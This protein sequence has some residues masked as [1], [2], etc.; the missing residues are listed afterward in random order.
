MKIY[1]I[2]ILPLSSLSAICQT[3]ESIDSFINQVCQTQFTDSVTMDFRSA[4]TTHPFQVTSYFKNDTLLMTVGRFKNSSR[5]RFTY[6][7]FVNEQYANVLCV[8]DI[9]SSKNKIIL[10]VYGREGI[11]IPSNILKITTA[12]PLEIN[13]AVLEYPSRLLD[14]SNYSIRAMF[15]LINRK[16][17]EYHFKGIL[18]EEVPFPPPCGRVAFAIAQKFEVIS[19][20]FPNYK[21][22]FV[23]IIKACPEGLKKFFVKGKTYDLDVLTNSGVTFSY[24]IDNKYQKDDLPIFWAKEIKIL[25]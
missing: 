22:K 13:S 8:R 23:I 3:V 24:S 20:N 17:T 9:D 15:A 12:E 4:D 14:Y 1:L 21:R 19:T 10:E 6:Y 16:A 5:L 25:D 2:L 7:E 18:K 11:G